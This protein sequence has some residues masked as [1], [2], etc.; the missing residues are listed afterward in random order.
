MADA[1]EA[2]ARA[3]SPSL[4]L[5]LASS[6]EIDG[7][8]AKAS[9]KVSDVA[10]R[11]LLAESFDMLGSAN[12][13]AVLRGFSAAT[14]ANGKDLRAVWSG[15]TFAGDGDHT[16][17]AIAHLIDEA[18]EDVFASTYSASSNS[19]YVQSLWRAVARGVKTTVLLDANLNDGKTA[20]WMQEKL[21]GAR[22]LGFKPGPLGGVQHSKVVVVDSSTAF[23]T[24]ANL[25]EAA[26]EKNLEAGVIIR[27][28]DFASSVRQRY[29]SLLNEGHL[30]LLDSPS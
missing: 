2:L 10:I 3:V 13:A 30:Y 21:H 19:A 17:A 4:A 18:T 29:A 14:K 23:I 24:S 27:D 25:S 20:A 16:T 11:D 1:I 28:P 6:L 26:H 8:L 12:L 7:S 22:F 9:I 5:K 15:P